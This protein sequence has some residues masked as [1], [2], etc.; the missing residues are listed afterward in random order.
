MAH[1]PTR[2]ILTIN[3]GSSSLKAGM[4]SLG[5]SE[6]LMLAAR[7]ERIGHSE[8]RLQITDTQ[9]ALLLDQQGHL[10]DHDAALHALFAWFQSHRSGTAFDAVGHR[11][12][13]DGDRYQEPQRITGDLIATLQQLVPLDPHHLLEALAAIQA[14][15][16]VYPSIPR[17]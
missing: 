9:G 7:A 8:G 6:T 12:D 4:Y 11:V 14:S 15:R 13:H 2:R 16:Q 5:A 1:T 3:T 17:W 10:P